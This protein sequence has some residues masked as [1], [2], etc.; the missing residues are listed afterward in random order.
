MRDLFL[1]SIILAFAVT[2]LK[3]PFLF[4]LLYIYVDLMA[5]QRLAYGFLISLP[6]SAAAVGLAF[7]TWF[8]VDDKTDAR[9]GLRQILIVVL[10]GWC[11]WTTS[12]AD[13]PVDAA[14]KWSWVWK[15]L[16]FAA[17]FPVTLRTRLRIEALVL[18]VVL[19]LSALCITGGIKT[20]GSGGG[21]Y[22]SLQLLV[23]D[24]SG[25]YEGSTASTVA[26]SIVPLILWLMRWGTIFPPDWK[27]RLFCLA[28]IFA[29]LLV[30]VG[31]QARTGLLCIALAA[32][33]WLR[34]ARHKFLWL[35]LLGVTTA[36]AIPFLPQSFTDRMSTIGE[37]KADASASTRVEVWKW[38]WEYVQQHPTGGGFDAYRQNRIYYFSEKLDTSDPANVVVKRSLE[39]DQGRAYHSAYFE[40]LG[41][42]GYFGF[43]LWAIIAIGGLLRMEILRRRYRV[44]DKAWA[45]ALATALQHAN[46]IYLLGAAFV[47]IAFQPVLFLIIGA[48]IGLDTY[49][50]RLRKAERWQPLVRKAKPP[51]L[52]TA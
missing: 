21:G 43:A 24:N 28:L 33:L 12:N 27:V 10:L 7:A 49:M 3:R 35:G 16:V 22:G 37:Y 32:L 51:T 41:E 20:I 30:P 40:M 29:C 17:F 1:L 36:L 18:M 11:A 52:A 8:A 42:Q 38:T 14:A 15:V 31:M 13:F 50:A 47:G 26:I 34:D 46:L 48:Q 9:V 19:A 5:P 44:G 45:G 2:A 4:V 6:V 23:S 25:L 39:I